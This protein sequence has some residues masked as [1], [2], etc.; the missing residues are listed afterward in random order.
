[1]R[2]TRR[3]RRSVV[4][5]WTAVVVLAVATVV[6]ISSATA[7]ARRLAASHGSP[8]VVP[9][10][11]RAVAA[12]EVLTDAEVVMRPVPRSFLPDAPV[13]RDPAGTAVLVDMVAG[14]VVLAARLARDGLRGPAALVPPGSRAVAVP[15][16]PGGRPPLRRGDRVDVL[17]TFP[18]ADVHGEGAAEEQPTFAVAADALVVDVAEDA[19]TVAVPAD[20]ATRVAFA[21]TT[22]AVTLALSGADG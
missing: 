4:L 6:A 18:P 20:D 21:V 13:A 8:R 2:L 14:E 19:V 15:T 3:L 5:Y 10:L 22:A 1:M 12:G 11:T 16:G 7:D 9:V 17:A